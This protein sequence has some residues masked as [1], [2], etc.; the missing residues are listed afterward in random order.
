MD[1]W[2]GLVVPNSMPLVAA[3]S[4]WFNFAGSPRP[5]WYT[6]RASPFVVRDATGAYGVTTDRS[7]DAK[8]SA[9]STCNARIIHTP[10]VLATVK[11]TSHDYKPYLIE[12]V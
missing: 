7:N 2:L 9:S 8:A 6:P 3:T 12:L 10:Q 4:T 11:T 5:S 1:K